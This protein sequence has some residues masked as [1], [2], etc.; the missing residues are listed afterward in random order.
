MGGLARSEQLDLPEEIVADPAG[1]RAMT[2]FRPEGLSRWP[3]L[4]DATNG[5]T[6]ER[7]MTLRPTSPPPHRALTPLRSYSRGA[8]FASLAFFA[9]ARRSRQ[10]PTAPDDRPMP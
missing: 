3:A 1:I 9:F 6:T 4:G 10:F 2:G 5:R 7:N 8:F